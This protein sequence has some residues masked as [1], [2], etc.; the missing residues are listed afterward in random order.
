MVG[1]TK[2][3]KMEILDAFSKGNQANDTTHDSLPNPIANMVELHGS[4]RQDADLA[5]AG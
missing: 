4:M 2:N 5:G 3:D 1:N